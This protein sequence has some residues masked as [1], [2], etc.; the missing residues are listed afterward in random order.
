MR[1]IKIDMNNLKNKI[2]VWIV[3][4]AF[5]CFPVLARAVTLYNPIG[6]VS[7]STIIGRVL[8]IIIGV[9]GAIALAVFIYSGFLWMTSAGDKGK[10]TKGKDGM[11]WAILGLVIIFSA[12]AIL[13][14]V[15]KALNQG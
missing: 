6:D 8:S 1:I 5:F 12:K 3:A 15:L 4:T 10:V 2:V 7:V 14:F 13:T 9:V 11:V